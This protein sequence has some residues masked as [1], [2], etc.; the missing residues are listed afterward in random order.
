MRIEQLE[1]S[2]LRSHR[3]NP[4][5]SL[6]LTG[7]ELVAVVGQTGAGKSSLLEAV[8][9]ALFGEST[10]SGQ[11]YEELSS[12]GRTEMS[13]RMVFTVGDDRYQLARTV[14]PDRN[15]DFK[16]KEIYLRRIAEDGTQL[17]HVD[18]VRKV[19]E[20]VSKLLGGITKE[21]FCQAVLLAQNRFAA[22]LEADPRERNLLL[23]ALLGLT[24]LQ[25]ARKALQ[26]ARKA[27][28]RNIERLTDRRD[29]L[30]GDPTSEARVAKRRAKEMTTVADRAEASADQLEAMSESAGAITK[31]IEE[32]TA[33]ATLRATSSGSEGLVRLGQATTA[34][35]DLVTTDDFLRGQEKKASEE[36]ETAKVVLKHATE[37]LATAEPEHGTLAQHTVVAERLQRLGELLGQIPNRERE[38]AEAEAALTACREALDQA[39]VA[40]VSAKAVSEA[41][42]EIVGKAEAEA[43]AK[44]TGVAA[45]EQAVTGAS[46][47]VARLQKQVELV[48]AA[49]EALSAVDA[50]I[51][52]LTEKL[53]PITERRDQARRTLDVAQRSDAAA[54]AAHGCQPGD[55][56]PVC[57][58]PLP[59]GWVQPESGELDEA[60]ALAADT[61]SE[62]DTTISELQ[63]AGE[64]RAG[65]VSRLTS[66]LSTVTAARDELAMLAEKSTFVPPPGAAALEPALDEPTALDTA[67]EGAHVLGIEVGNW[68]ESLSSAV[69]PLR[70]ASEQSDGRL[71]EAHQ[72]LKEAETAQGVA[73]KAVNDANAALAGAV[74]THDGRLRALEDSRTSLASTI[75]LVDTRWRELIDPAVAKSLE[76]AT[77]RLEEDRI[78]VEAAATARDEATIAVTNY[79]RALRDLS[80]DRAEKITAPFAS[81]TATLSA[82]VDLVNSLA[83]RVDT[84]PA[85]EV[86]GSPSPAALLEAVSDI[87][88]SAVAAVEAAGVRV[89][90]LRTAVDDLVAPAAEVV[91]TL[92]GLMAEADPT[93]IEI[94]DAPDPGDPL[95]VTTYARVQQIVG[96]ARRLA[97]EAAAAAQKA[98]EAVSIAKEL[99]KRI[100]AL[101]AWRADVDGGVDVLKKEAF[102]TWARNV[103]IA[104]LVDTASDIFSEITSS[105]Y[106]FDE[107]LR[108][109]DDQAG[110]NR[111][112]SSLSGGEKFEAALALALGVA[113]IAGRSG[114]RIDTLFLDEGFAGLDQ[115]H[116]NRTIDALESQVEAGRCIVLITHI[117]SV[118]D[119]IQDVLLVQPDGIGGST[120]T[121][122]NE[123]ERFELGAD[124]DMAVP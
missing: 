26:T 68:L 119:R 17:M 45:A 101:T 121:W 70:E 87:E 62:F 93:G 16:P 92:V 25:D 57:D 33:A 19:N 18:G 63:T 109:V 86:G 10:Y 71:K 39:E 118:A 69:A 124:L 31:E 107:T 3:G 96:R 95:G 106:R 32:L 108:I 99:D 56:C 4:P 88:S 11:A 37:D 100:G 58:R 8:T 66:A 80:K 47:I 114:V 48:D 120:L 41:N 52:E 105:R 1:I 35:T 53:G 72:A 7:K 82:V 111:K 123:E 14:R 13:V 65:Y 40:A 76:A 81:L 90:T 6:D 27:A 103:R 54:T 64:R 5:T 46:D 85:P 42:R 116:L 67:A 97:E 89:V 79:E 49:H 20:A 113:E 38:S 55:D 28:Q 115:A 122:L 12:D 84:A 91:T 59:A 30:P 9:F 61:A 117:G 104:D 98:K 50:Q 83:A 36:F 43:A 51:A 29:L 2:G 74:S 110:A 112:A 44:G 24:A 15:G 73:D 77:A 22:F 94:G 102:P 78:R 23:D 60:R 34:L 75:E 21:Q